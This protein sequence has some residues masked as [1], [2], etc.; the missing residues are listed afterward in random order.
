MNF[1]LTTSPRRECDHLAC[2]RL[3]FYILLCFPV[4]CRSLCHLYGGQPLP[5]QAVCLVSS[6]PQL[7]ARACRIISDTL[8]PRPCQVFE[9][10]AFLGLAS[11]S[12][13]ALDLTLRLNLSCGKKKSTKRAPL[14]HEETAQS[15]F[16]NEHKCILLLTYGVI[17][18]F[19]LGLMGKDKL[20]ALQVLVSIYKPDGKAHPQKATMPPGLEG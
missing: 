7:G 20:E 14:P 8:C 5:V 17:S 12:P 4:D 2:A 16:H 3:D 6:P 9:R 18:L 13:S 10:G 15:S 11:R 19:L 1:I